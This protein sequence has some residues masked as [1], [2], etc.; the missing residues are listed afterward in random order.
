[1]Q[2]YCRIALC[3]WEINEALSISIIKQNKVVFDAFKATYLKSY[4][5]IAF[6]FSCL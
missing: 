6:V 4:I 3:K 2:S 5:G 1:V